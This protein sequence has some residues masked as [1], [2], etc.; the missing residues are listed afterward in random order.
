MENNSEETEREETGD[1]S[2]S[3][4]D[5]HSSPFV[6][7]SQRFTK[8][9]PANHRPCSDSQTEEIDWEQQLQL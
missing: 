2:K 7:Q 9:L 1:D 5:P 6:R 8:K 4:E 3:G